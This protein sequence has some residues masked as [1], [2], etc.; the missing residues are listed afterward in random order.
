M[1]FPGGSDGKASAYNAGDTGLMEDSNGS[2]EK[3]LDSG[4]I[5]KIGIMGLEVAWERLMPTVTPRLLV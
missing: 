3:P 5:L 1:D 4:Y 2:D